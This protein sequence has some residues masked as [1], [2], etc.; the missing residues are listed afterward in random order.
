MV[1]LEA[2]DAALTKLESQDARSADILKMRVIWG[3]T[4]AEIA[5]SLD[6]SVSTIDRDWKWAK[7]WLADELGLI[8]S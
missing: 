5:D 8:K 2:L 1:E 7:A 3:M 6:V 4:V